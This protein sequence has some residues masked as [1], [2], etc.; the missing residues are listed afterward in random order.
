MP[1]EELKKVKVGDIS[2]SPSFIFLWAATEHLEDARELMKEWGFKRC[3]DIVWVKTNLNRKKFPE[4]HEETLFTRVKEHC[5]M[6][7]KG[8][9]KKAFD[10]NFIH[11]NID[12]DVVI[13]EE[14]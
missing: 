12:I 2:D 9:S 13:T 11:P 1:L 10:N 7:Y 3:E 8:D 4:T 6:G 5:L 14:P